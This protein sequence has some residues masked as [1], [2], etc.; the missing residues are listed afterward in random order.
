MEIEGLFTDFVLLVSAPSIREGRPKLQ[1]QRLG[2]SL[3]TV[4]VVDDDPETRSLLRMILEADGHVVVEAMHG[5]QALEIIGPD[6]MPDVVVTDLMMPV[7]NGPE[8]IGRLQS[9]P[10]TAAIPIIVVS[11]SSTDAL[12][13]QASGLVQAIVTKPF[14]AAV[15]ADCI[16][17]VTQGPIRPQPVA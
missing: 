3:S 9:Q 15:F 10:R 6:P 4:M 11:A 13:L 17:A 12:A 14:D 5:A 1:C 16:R 2:P 8:L 7:L